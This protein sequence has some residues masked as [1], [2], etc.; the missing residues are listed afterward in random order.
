MPGTKNVRN[1]IE[2]PPLSTMLFWFS[3]PNSSSIMSGNMND[4]IARRRSRQKARCS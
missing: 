3:E 4:K 2:P 1:G